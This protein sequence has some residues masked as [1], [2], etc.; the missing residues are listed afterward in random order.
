MIKKF[1]TGVID[2]HT[3]SPT[4][5]RVAV[6]EYSDK[7]TVWITLRGYMERNALKEAVSDIRPSR[8][9][10]VVTDEALR[11]AA[12]DIFSPEHGSRP[13]I[14]K[15]LILVTDDKSTGSESLRLAAEPLRKKGV[16]VY[17]V[18]IGEKVDKKEIGDLVPD[19]T[20]VSPIDNPEETRNSAPQIANKID[21]NVEKST[22]RYFI[23]AILFIQICL[24][25]KTFGNFHFPLF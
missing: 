10:S 25:V 11:M 3:I 5:T 20:N 22:Y 6:M 4:Q 8:G 24:N 19:N 13:G 9:K 23:Y 2:R 15:V 7:P 12:V 14:P 16:T 18:A 17:I 1:V 21:K